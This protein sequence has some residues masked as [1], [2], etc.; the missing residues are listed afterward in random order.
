VRSEVAAQQRATFEGLMKRVGGLPK[1]QADSLR[2]NPHLVKMA[3]AV[4]A[5]DTDGFTAAWKEHGAETRAAAI[6]DIKQRARVALER[7]RQAG[8]KPKA[9]D[10]LR[11]AEERR[12]SRL[13]TQ[14]LDDLRSR[15]ET[16]P[17]NYKSTRP[18]RES[19]DAA[20]EYRRREDQTASDEAVQILRMNP[21][22]SLDDILAH[23]AVSGRIRDHVLAVAQVHEDGLRAI[24]G[25]ARDFASRGATREEINQI[26]AE[27]ASKYGMTPEDVLNARRRSAGITR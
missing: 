9:T 5:G 6:E 17:N 2:T 19:F 4:D 20:A 7:I 26:A 13:T 14:E 21:G 1:E 23:P 16:D 22:A 12:L 11:T 15:V 24:E 25:M 3:A 10:T 18:T 8:T 27:M